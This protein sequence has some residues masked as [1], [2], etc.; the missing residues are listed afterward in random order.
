MLQLTKNA[1]F[2]P[3]SITNKNR[4]YIQAQ[5]IIKEYYDLL[6]DDKKLS[7]PPFDESV[8]A[9]EDVISMLIKAQRQKC[10]YC[11]ILLI[12][13]PRKFISHY[14][15]LSNAIID[16]QGELE[17]F[18]RY[19]WFAYEWQNLLLI[20][21]ECNQY[22][23][24][25]FPLAGAVSKP[26]STW[27][28][29]QV[30][31]RPLLINPFT[32]RVKKHI[33]F[34]CEGFAVGISDEGR[35]TID[36]INL[37]REKLRVERQ[38][39]ISST[40]AVI[41]DSRKLPLPEK[42]TM[43]EGAL[44]PGM[45]FF[46]A[47]SNAIEWVCNNLNSGGAEK[48]AVRGLTLVELILSMVES[49]NPDEWASSIAQASQYDLQFAI[50]RRTL[51][52]DLDKFSYLSS[53]E[54]SDFK[55]LGS[56]WIDFSTTSNDRHSKFAPCTMLL[57]ENAAGKSSIL[58]AIS[59]STMAAS[60]RRRSGVKI[61][62]LIPVSTDVAQSK[63]EKLYL[64]ANFEDGSST[65]LT[66]HNGRLKLEGK[67]KGP[68]LAY[69]ARRFFIRG[70]YAGTKT[71]RNRSLFDEGASLQD[72][73]LWLIVA[74]QEKFEAVA[75]ALHSL[76]TL[77]IEQQVVRDISG[78]YIRS[79]G[80]KIPVGYLSDGY[81]TIF[82]L[83]V[84]IMRE[85]LEDHGSLEYAQAVVLIDEIENHLHPSWKKKL[86][87]SLRAAMPK[88]QFIASTHDP[89]C[90]R[91]MRDGEVK[92]LYRDR[93]S[94]IRIMEELPSISTLSVEQILTS[95]YFGLASTEDDSQLR[96]ANILAKYVGR[97]DGSMS[98]KEKAERDTA[99]RDYSGTTMIGS[100][101]DRQVMAE[102]LGRHVRKYEGQS[103]FDKSAARKDSVEL[104][105]DV[106]ERSMR[107]D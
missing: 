32:D 101:V 35:K 20:C 102:A 107:R 104:I 53:I 59:L 4:S 103:L 25:L 54:V 98:E 41:N 14:R 76:L 44:S 39:A 62:Y 79:A 99:L 55:G 70:Q 42:R 7:R 47:V 10:A 90:L 57:G 24:N 17:V 18:D 68:F 81:K 21:P 94:Q 34:D 64:R 77:N 6:D 31:E 11:E 22:K 23:L 66:L 63:R 48:L 43:I 86:L 69:G 85:I 28:A 67:A 61:D 83:S 56:C 74:S 3:V 33:S 29:A 26:F 40:L 30:Q 78:V 46:G 52:L 72:P 5:K 97:S 1:S 12:G 73:S 38:K 51:R 13:D 100:S 16:L 106:L 50:R 91:G 84:D 19:A 96:A 60:I 93:D 45:P 15:P 95:E 92:V 37:N 87:T 8:L 65:E 58:Q 82:A 49:R 89:L 2:K 71:S 88:V 75:R 27:K 36:V 9:G 105:M 80:D